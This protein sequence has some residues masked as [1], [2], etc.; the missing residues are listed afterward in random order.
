MRRGVP[1][2]RAA[3]RIAAIIKPEFRFI[4]LQL[5]L[6]PKEPEERLTNRRVD[7]ANL[8]DRLGGRNA[9]RIDRAHKVGKRYVRRGKGGLQ[10]PAS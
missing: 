7:E 6:A 8:G 10:Q 5:M 1:P 3:R 9:T 2:R 4:H